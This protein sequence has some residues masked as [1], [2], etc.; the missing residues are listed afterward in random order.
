MSLGERTAHTSDRR[1]PEA[2]ERRVLF[3]EFPG[4]PDA[5]EEVVLPDQPTL[6]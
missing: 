4:Q 2:V 3:T 6:V 1:I 5:L